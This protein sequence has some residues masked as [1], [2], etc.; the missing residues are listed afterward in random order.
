[1]SQF[2]WRPAF[3]VG[4]AMVDEQHK[5]LFVLLGALHQGIHNRDSRELVLNTLDELLDY[6]RYHFSAEEAL[7]QQAGYPDYLAHKALHDALLAKVVGM[8]DAAAGSD[9]DMG[10]TLLEFLN[11]WLVKH[12]LESDK[13]I[14]RFLDAGR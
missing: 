11:D 7:M 1:M 10:M 8:R 3:R 5:Q 9:S 4:D 2:E 6:T 12:I 14:G 13:A